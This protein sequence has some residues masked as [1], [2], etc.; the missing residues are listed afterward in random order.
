MRRRNSSSG[1]CESG[2]SAARTQ[3]RSVLCCSLRRACS[4]S[5]SSRG[6]C[7]SRSFHPIAFS[8]HHG[9]CLLL[10]FHYLGYLLLGAH[11]L[12]GHGRSPGDLA[13]R[14]VR[15]YRQPGASV[16][17]AKLNSIPGH[18]QDVLYVLRPLRLRKLA[19]KLQL[20]GRVVD[21]QLRGQL[22]ALREPREY[23]PQ[24]RNQQL[25]LE[26]GDGRAHVLRQHAGTLRHLRGRQGRA[27]KRL[28]LVVH[29]HRLDT[30]A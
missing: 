25:V 12:T 7:T 15:V 26:P 30:V 8:L 4:A 1:F 18:L 19:Y 23:G 3:V 6:C 17:L 11:D 5:E 2:A 16:E 28:E 21:L 24:Y 14:S 13:Q 27:P 10:L 22:T 9:L 29:E 20:Q